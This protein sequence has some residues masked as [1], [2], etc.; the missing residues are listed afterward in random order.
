M[1]LHAVHHR[2][3]RVANGP[4]RTTGGRTAEWDCKMP[5]PFHVGGSDSKASAPEPL[6]PCQCLKASFVCSL[7]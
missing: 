7:A 6:G 1:R 3:R 2:A 4:S 5:G